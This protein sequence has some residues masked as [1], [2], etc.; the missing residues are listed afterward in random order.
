VPTRQT[1]EPLQVPISP[2]L[3]TGGSARSSH[4][5]HDPHSRGLQLLLSPNNRPAHDPARLGRA[6]AEH[7]VADTTP[8]CLRTPP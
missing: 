4:R 2:E 5:L 3:Q 7:Q 6:E 1:E 8:L